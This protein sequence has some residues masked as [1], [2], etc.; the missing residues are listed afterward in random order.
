MKKKTLLI[1]LIIP[2]IISLLTFVSV[3]ILRNTVASDISDISWTYQENQGFKISEQPY[4]LN[5]KPVYDES[6]VLAPGNNLVWKVN[7]L[8]GS[9]TDCAKIEKIDSSY[10]LYALKEGECQVICQNERGSVSKYFNAIIY[11]NG[12]IIVNPIL[13]ISGSNIDPI[14][15]FG[16]YDLT[17]D[18]VALDKAKS[19]P[20]K[21]KLEANEIENDN[22]VFAVNE[23]DN[24]TIDENFNVTIN[25]S[26]QA[27]IRFYTNSDPFVSAYYEFYIVEDGYNI[28]SY[29]DLLMCTNFSSEGKNIVLQTNLESLENVYRK[30]SSQK[31]INKKLEGKEDYELFGNYN[32]STQR[33]NFENELKVIESTYN[34]KF[35]EDYNS[36][37][38][39]DSLEPSIKVGLYI[40]KD[41]YGNGF[42]VNGNGLTY[43]NHGKIAVN[44]KLTPT[45][46]LDYFFGPLPFVTIGAIDVGSVAKVY[47]QDNSLMYIAKD[48]VKINDIKVK[49]T[50]EI[51][52]MYNLLYTGTVIDVH[53][54][55]VSIK[56]SILS[57]GRT[58]VRG[59]SSDGLNITNCILK[60]A[61]QFLLSV[62]SDGYNSYQ[63]DKHV[64]VM[65]N[66][67]DYSNRLDKLFDYNNPTGVNTIINE[68]L[69]NP[70]LSNENELEKVMNTLNDIQDGLDNTNNLINS[71]N[72]VIYVD[73]INLNKVYFANSG[74]F[75]I[76]FETMFNGPYLYNGIPSDVHQF[77]DIFNSLIPNKI[78]GTSYPVNI[79]ADDNVKFYDWKKIETIDTSILIEENIS[80]LIKQL[81][82]KEFELSMEDY[83]PM[84]SVLKE[85]VNK[86]GYYFNYE[87]EQYINSKVAWFGGGLNLSNTNLVDNNDDELLTVDIAKSILS[88]KYINPNEYVRLLSKCVVLASGTHPFKF[89][90]NGKV[91][92]VPE[93]FNKVPQ[94][95][96][97][98]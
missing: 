27:L 20:A 98:R 18:E 31:F 60:N 46:G 76:G 35:I 13:P 65:Y 57:N 28:Y 53:G 96:D 25:G 64:D 45:N 1:L 71:N 8:D 73:T 30:D 59:F 89:L 2:F 26:G 55:N 4:K 36:S 95:N 12:A 63:D 66:S 84:K 72:E 92:N 47:A 34:T 80:E 51:D 17:Y 67:L 61:A 49:N 19:S 38:K 24:I 54:K 82:G 7:N 14:R 77:L 42:S 11:E 9:E 78:A 75:S 44:G 69:K 22:E 68:I 62:G 41:I 70:N 97:L 81:F 21:F 32:F 93:E 6:L 39:K 87:N 48:N 10:Y 86:N 50:N 23:T 40:Q 43:P 5:A 90:T 15:Y 94:I 58:V 91:T 85:E 29:N 83:F 79:L 56:N 88:G 52:N 3:S 74:V 16:E 37:N 33:F